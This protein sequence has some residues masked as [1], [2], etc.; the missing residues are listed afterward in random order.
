M[1]RPDS[2]V[3]EPCR[4]RMRINDLAVVILQKIGAVAV[5]NAGRA[6]GQRGGVEPDGMPLPAASTP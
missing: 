3:I 5:K 6:A 1:F 4:N 2:G